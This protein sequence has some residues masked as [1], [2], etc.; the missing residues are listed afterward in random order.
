MSHDNAPVRAGAARIAQSRGGAPARSAPRS[1]RSAPKRSGALS[2]PKSAPRPLSGAVGSAELHKLAE[3][4][5]RCDDK[6]RLVALIAAARIEAGSRG[7]LGAA[8][9]EV[10]RAIGIAIKAL[11]ADPAAAE[12]VHAIAERDAAGGWLQ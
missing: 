5:A 10:L 6:G 9:A 11:G 1:G 2:S 8:V 7:E 12:L 3:Q 4:I